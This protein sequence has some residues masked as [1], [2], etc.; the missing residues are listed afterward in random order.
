MLNTNDNDTDKGKI[1][2]RPDLQPLLKGLTFEDYFH[3]KGRTEKDNPETDRSIAE[4]EIDGRKF[5]LKRHNGV[6]WAEI[7]KNLHA[8]KK[9]ITSAYNEY[10]AL[11]HLPE[12]G[13]PTAP[14]VAYGKTAGSPAS[15]RSFVMTESLNQTESLETFVPRFF[16]PPFSQAKIRFKYALI[17]RLADIGRRLHE[18]GLTHQDFYLCHFRIDLSCGESGLSSENLKLFLMDLHRI[19]RPSLF[20]LKYQT[21][22]LAALYASAMDCGLTQRDCLRFVRHYMAKS[23][24]KDITQMERAFWRMVEKRA[25]RLYSRIHS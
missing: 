17:A 25:A 15:I 7:L 13:I 11:Q 5:F 2:V 3:L 19:Q 4:V 18:L 8:L 10:W 6:G 20:R 21:K 1:V 14:F 12:M 16:Q 24:L 9:P 23:S 22:D